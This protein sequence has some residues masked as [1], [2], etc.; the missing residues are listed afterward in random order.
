MKRLLPSSNATSPSQ[1]KPLAGFFPRAASS[2]FSR[3]ESGG[4]VQDKALVSSSSPP[5]DAESAASGGLKA[6]AA[7]TQRGG[8]CNADPFSE[9]SLS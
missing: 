3:S 2:L 1:A 4:G 5:I 7:P 9:M 6:K 8:L